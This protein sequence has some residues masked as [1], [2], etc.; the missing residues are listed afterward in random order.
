MIETREIKLGKASPLM[1]LRGLRKSETCERAGL[2]NW[3]Q[4]PAELVARGQAL[5]ISKW[6]DS[7]AS[8]AFRFL[9]CSMVSSKASRTARTS[10]VRYGSSAAVSQQRRPKIAHTVG[11]GRSWL[12]LAYDSS[13]DTLWLESCIHLLG[14]CFS[15]ILIEVCWPC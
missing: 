4:I 15:R 6:D 12:S 10:H 7:T 8:A 14:E 3:K 2:E 13:E 1:A 11:L 5:A 9:R